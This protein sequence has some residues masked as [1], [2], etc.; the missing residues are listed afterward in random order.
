MPA[1]CGPARHA[2]VVSA[3]DTRGSVCSVIGYLSSCDAFRNVA[4]GG[5]CVQVFHFR[6]AGRERVGNDQLVCAFKCLWQPHNG[7]TVPYLYEVNSSQIRRFSWK[8]LELLN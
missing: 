3:E 8:Y 6:K 7:E 1:G 5:Q 4:K 2:G